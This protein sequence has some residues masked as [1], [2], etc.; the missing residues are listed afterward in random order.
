MKVR[1]G[2]IGI[3]GAGKDHC[4][5]LSQNA[6][7]E[8]TA[9]AD[10]DKA[11]VDEAVQE[12]GVR[13]FTDYRELLDAGIVDAVSI[14]TPHNLHFQMVM[15]SLNAGLHVLSEKPIATR[16]SEADAM[17]KTAKDRKLKYS[18]CHQYRIHRSALK[19]K[20]IVDTGDIGNIMRVLWTW[21][22]YRPESYYARYPW[23]GTFSAAGGGVLGYFGIHDLDL[24]CWIIGRPV[25]VNAMIGNQLHSFGTEDI[26]C[27]NV[28]FAN[29]AQG[30]LQLTL[31]QPRGYS[32]RQI[33]GDRG[34]A[35]MPEVKSL[36]YDMD[37]E[38]L[39]G[40]YRDSLPALCS[41]QKQPYDQ[42]D[43]S[44]QRITLSDGK[45]GAN[46]RVNHGG[47]RAYMEKLTDPRRVLRRLG[48]MKSG[49]KKTVSPA[50]RRP[51]PREVVINSFID[52]IIND[53][54]PVITGESTLPALELMNALML[55]AIREKTVTL[56][57]DRD[58]Y[59]MLFN[60]LVS[61]KAAVP[62]F[63][64]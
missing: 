56:P 19:L 12:L 54:D 25:Q 39:L 37:E 53:K 26:V 10:I 1:Y 14:A 8:L 3:K 62:R 45:H 61:G 38:I 31:N 44:W 2:V 55:S 50:P 59:D 7:A 51:E 21:W 27:A 24:I 57:I 23:K 18:V 58:E 43:I 46:D 28:L 47:M 41:D 36:T 32:T 22:E 49:D 9:V 17:I 33:A 20:E 34:I 29:G 13:G 64:A 11:A 42:P 6:G 40:K 48:L 4:S 16:V 15:D 35:V 52:A 5:L 63:R 60:D 30:S